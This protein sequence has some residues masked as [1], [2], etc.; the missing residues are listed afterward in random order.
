[1]RKRVLYVWSGS[2]HGVETHATSASDAVDQAVRANLPCVLGSAI[3]VSLKPKGPHP[4][5]VFFEVPYE[6]Q[7]P[8]LFAGDLEVQV[9]AVEK[10]LP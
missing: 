10:E 8:E 6:E 9:A 4:L 7:F 1:V 3:R 5:D 2:L